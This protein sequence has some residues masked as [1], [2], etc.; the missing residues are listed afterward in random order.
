MQVDGIQNDIFIGKRKN[1]KKNFIGSEICLVTREIMDSLLEGLYSDFVI[2]VPYNNDNRVKLKEA[3]IYYEQEFLEIKK[4]RH[5]NFESDNNLT[6]VIIMNK[7]L[8]I[9]AGKTKHKLKF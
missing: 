9:D 7:D 5:R 3:I 8:K 2:K 4:E 6:K 1:F